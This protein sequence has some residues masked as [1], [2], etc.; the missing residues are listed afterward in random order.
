MKSDPIEAVRAFHATW[1]SRPEKERRN[2]F[3]MALYREER[4]LFR[5][6]QKKT[7]LL[8][9]LPAEILADWLRLK[10]RRLGDATLRAHMPEIV[11]AHLASS[12][13]GFERFLQGILET[14]RTAPELKQYLQQLS[15]AANR[16][17]LS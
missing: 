10:G 4:N 11:R 14:C 1:K 6:F 7:E 13:K 12:E 9:E 15:A 5:Q 2:G 3:K 16:R 17:Q 8:R